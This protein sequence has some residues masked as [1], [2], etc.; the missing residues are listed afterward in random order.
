MAKK[1]SWKRGAKKGAYVFA[2]VVVGAAAAVA[3]VGGTDKM[4]E[5]TVAVGIAA[6]IAAIRVGVNWYKVNYPRDSE[7]RYKR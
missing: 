4:G 1:Y 6:G 3:A 2:A 7:K 5:V